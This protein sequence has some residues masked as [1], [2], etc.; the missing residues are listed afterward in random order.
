[1]AANKT[2]CTE[3]QMERKRRKKPRTQQFTPCFVSQDGLEYPQ[4]WFGQLVLQVVG[5]IYGDTV[6]Q[7]I[8]W[9]L[10]GSGGGR[11]GGREGGGEGGREGG[12]EGGREGGRE[13]GEGGRE[14]VSGGE[15]RE[16][17]Q[18]Q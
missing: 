18:A 9:I 17:E 11:E 13:G 6:V 16:R 2:N 15:R 4:Q 3:I 5:G 7:D 10:G 8:E 12:G 14:G 1:M